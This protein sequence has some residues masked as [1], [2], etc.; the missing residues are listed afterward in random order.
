MEIEETRADFLE[1]MD[2]R[3]TNERCPDRM[4]MIRRR[5]GALIPKRFDA[6][7]STVKDK[8]VR[9][10]RAHGRQI[11]DLSDVDS[12]LFPNLKSSAECARYETQ[13]EWKRMVLPL[14][15]IARLFP[16]VFRGGEARNDFGSREKGWWFALK[17]NFAY[18]GASRS[19]Y[20]IVVAY[21]WKRNFT[22]GS[23][24]VYVLVINRQLGTRREEF[25]RLLFS[26]NR[27]LTKKDTQQ[28]PDS[29]VLSCSI[30]LEDCL[31]GY[32]DFTNEDELLLCDPNLFLQPIAYVMA[33]E[34]QHYPLE[35]TTVPEDFNLQEL[36]AFFSRHRHSSPHPG[37]EWFSPEQTNGREWLRPNFPLR[38]FSAQAVLEAQRERQFSAQQHRACTLRIY[39]NQAADNK[40]EK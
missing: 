6:V 29:E 32:V 34:G 14:R 40:K 26:E 28:Q 12:I 10:A 18:A 37:P 35:W 27:I 24:P 33:R 36:N 19:S 22:E 13:P 16:V 9:F 4:F 20:H 25:A 39:D 3:T 31:A 21:K 7:K 15:D 23:E 8:F 2:D 11:G 5:N 38:K 1:D 17:P 30:C